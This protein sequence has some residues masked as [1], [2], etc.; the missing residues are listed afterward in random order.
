[1]PNGN[2]IKNQMEILELTSPWMGKLE[3]AEGK[4]SELKDR[5]IKII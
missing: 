2:C 5:S 3:V 1:M 4:V